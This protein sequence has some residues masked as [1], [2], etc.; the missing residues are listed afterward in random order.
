MACHTINKGIKTE[1]MF[2]SMRFQKGMKA[3]EDKAKEDKAKEIEDARALELGHTKK[4]EEIKLDAANKINAARDRHGAPEKAPAEEV[5]VKE[6]VA[7]TCV[8]FPLWQSDQPKDH[9]IA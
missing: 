4:M 1:C 6:I 9:T 2:H 8:G 7:I 3:L 5:T